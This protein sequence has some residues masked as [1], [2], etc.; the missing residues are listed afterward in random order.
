MVYSVLCG[1][2][3]WVQQSEI[4]QFFAMNILQKSIHQKLK[5]ILFVLSN[6][7]EH[8]WIM[9]EKNSSL[10]NSK[11]NAWDTLANTLD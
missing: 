8:N 11:V 10:C 2:P 1:D 7:T 9:Q 4:G 6:Q 3:I 5:H